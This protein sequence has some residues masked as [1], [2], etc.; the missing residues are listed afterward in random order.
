MPNILAMWTALSPATGPMVLQK[1]A[2]EVIHL[3]ISAEGCRWEALERAVFK[4]L[5]LT[6]YVVWESCRNL[7]VFL[8]VSQ[9]G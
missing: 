4:S 5:L 9:W 8:R 1:T 6:S 2:Q 3:P 7:F